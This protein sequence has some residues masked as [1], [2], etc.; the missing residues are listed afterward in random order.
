MV[1]FDKFFSATRD[2][3][4][5]IEIADEASV[6]GEGSGC[7]ANHVGSNTDESLCNAKISEFDVVY[8]ASFVEE[9]AFKA[10]SP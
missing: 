2:T 6:T 10:G 1:E 4:S 5:K 3:D 8:I 9:A 7:A